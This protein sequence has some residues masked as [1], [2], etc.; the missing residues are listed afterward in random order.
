MTRF[1]V[2]VLFL[3]AIL[4]MAII[5][6]P[7]GAAGDVLNASSDH[8]Q[9]G[10]N[11]SETVPRSPDP[12]IPTGD[13][14][15]IPLC[16]AGAPFDASLYPQDTPQSDPIVFQCYWDG[17]GRVFIS[18]NQ[19]LVTGVY[20]DDGFNVTVQPSG[21][22]FDAP[23]HTATQHPVI[24]LTSGMTPG[25]NS[26]TL[27]VQNWNGLSMSYG[28]LPGW[29]WQ[30]PSIVQVVDKPVGDITV[31]PLCLAGTPFDATRYPQNLPQSD[32]MVFPCSWDGTGRV[33]ISGN[34]SAVT[35]VYADDGY[36]VT[37]QPSGASFDAPDHT[38]SRHPVVEL[39]SGMTPGLNTFTIVVRNWKGLSMSYGQLLGSGWQT[40]FIV[41][42]T[43]TTAP[44]LVM[45]SVG[46]FRP[47]THTFSLK[48]GSLTT[49]IDW[50]TGT[51]LPLTGDWNADGI[52]DVGVFRPS[53]HR[54]LLKNGSETPAISW[55]TGTDLP[56]AGDWN[57][58]SLAEVGV[59][60]PSIHKF[61]LKNG[62]ERTV[63]N[64]G[65]GT[66]VPV[67]GDWNGDGLDDVG[68]F[69]P[70]I[71]KFVLKNGTERTVVNFALGTDVPVAG[72][73]NGDGLDDVG[74]FRPSTHRFLLKNGSATIVIN[75]GKGTDLPVAGTWS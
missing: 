11:F 74:V 66:D 35:G 53:T 69:R 21:A 10:I 49:T 39:T 60:R 73:W 57:G 29:G 47:T 52:D 13:V 36:T 28:Q 65:L 18:G 8:H 4:A 64:F 23:V 70:S 55:G 56:V 42:E 14:T 3:A 51:D 50:G 54:F 58:D 16:P 20:A 67:T 26:F 33:Y 1:F 62:T 27:V 25:L 59:F 44:S 9:P 68:V 12:G 72:D 19:S 37:I 17:T 61:V 2:R 38:A 30:T 31:V 22:S 63:I 48:N 24:E 40:P 15:V 34:H 71:H 6:I 45:D 5:V 43:D 75:W 7:A 46:I 41:K 32:P